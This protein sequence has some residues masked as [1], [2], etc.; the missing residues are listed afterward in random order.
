MW[1]Q[2]IAT[3][4]AMFKLS[5]CLLIAILNIKSE[6][7]IV[8]LFSPKPSE[9]NNKILLPNHWFSVKSFSEL[10]SKALT[11]KPFVFK[12]LNV[13]FILDTLKILRYS[14]PPLA[15][16]NNNLLF[17][18]NERSLTINPSKL[19]LIAHLII[20][21]IFLGSETS[22]RAKKFKFFFYLLLENL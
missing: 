19:K 6:L 15:L 21:P 5:I 13:V 20:E 11:Q 12:N 4:L 22:S 1:W 18:G 7:A 9:P 14:I 2:T 16:L 3:E 8:F 17:D 10:A